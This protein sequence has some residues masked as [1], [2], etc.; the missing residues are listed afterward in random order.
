MKTTD[1]GATWTATQLD[2][3]TTAY[4]Y[5]VAIDPVDTTV[6]YAGGYTDT[7]TGVL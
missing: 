4:G 2:T 1:Q 5:S 6:V 3:A 7:T